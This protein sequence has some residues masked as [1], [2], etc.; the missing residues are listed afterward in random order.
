MNIRI[1][2]SQKNR[3]TLSDFFNDLKNYSDLL[4]FLVKR[5]IKVIYKQTI[6]GFMWAVIQPLLSMIIFTFIFGK[7]ANVPSDDIPYPLFAFCAL[8]PWT[9][10]SQTLNNTSLSLVNNI[11]I[12]SKVYFPRV[13]IILAPVFAKLLDFLISFSVLIFLLFFYERDVTINLI[14]LPL[15]IIMLILLAT[16]FGFWFSALSV[17]YRDVK[18]ILPFL[19]QFLLYLA[20]VVWSVTL[21]KENL[22]HTYF[23]I[24]GIY[25]MVGIIDGFRSSLLGISEIRWEIIM[26]GFVMTLIILITGFLYFRKTEQIVVDIS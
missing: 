11:H 21:L 25:P 10:F 18:F 16:G 9:Y 3:G 4:I 8:V 12:I 7:L 24:Y 2:I 23:W 5:D 26:P 17:R 13:I 20:P 22:S 1:I 15:W 19:S 6:L 14:Y